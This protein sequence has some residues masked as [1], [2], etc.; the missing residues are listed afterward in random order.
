MKPRKSQNRARKTLTLKSLDGYIAAMDIYSN[1]FAHFQDH[2]EL[3]SL[4]PEAEGNLIA[5]PHCYK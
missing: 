4:G 5:L 3:R 2:F 1:L